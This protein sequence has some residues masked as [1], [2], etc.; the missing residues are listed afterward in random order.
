MPDKWRSGLWL[1]VI[2]LL[3]ACQQA[4]LPPAEPQPTPQLLTLAYPPALR[5][6]QPAFNT[7]ALEKPQLTVLVVEAE[8]D[9]DVSLYW[10]EPDEIAGEVILLGED[11][12]VLIANPASQAI[13][14]TL[15]EVRQLFSGDAL[16]WPDGAPLTV[17]A[18]PAG[19]AVQNALESAL[20]SPVPRSV[21]I[22]IAPSLE[23]MQQYVADDPTALGVLPQSWLNEQFKA[24]DWEIDTRQPVLASFTGARAEAFVRCLQSTVVEKLGE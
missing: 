16:A 9:P 11:G 18:L 6:L 5:W 13:S 15:A 19:H 2:L 7:C 17:Y 1:I 22:Q 24:L 20:G 3:A 14:L 4:E 8:A 23:A 10:G 12:L 21:N